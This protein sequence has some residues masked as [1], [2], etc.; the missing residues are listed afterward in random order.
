MN[1]SDSSARFSKYPSTT[2]ITSAMAVT[3][4]ASTRLPV[5][6]ATPIAPAIQIAAPVESVKIAPGIG[7]PVA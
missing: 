1:H 4:A 7:Y 6:H 5:A 2:T 3:S